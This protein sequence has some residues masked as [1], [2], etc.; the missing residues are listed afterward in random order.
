MIRKKICM[1]GAFAVGKTSL[2]ERFVKS[3]FNERYQTSLGVK[4]DKKSLL[5]DDQPLELILWDL[6]GEDEFVSLRLPYL[7]GAAGL[8]LVVDGTRPETLDTALALRDKAITEIGEVPFALLINKADLT[9]GWH[10]DPCD[11]DRLVA[12]G[13]TALETSAKTGRGVEEAFE[14]L[15]KEMLE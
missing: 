15:G 10:I 6:A 5:I 7:R 13:W 4:I 14:T 12:R 11:I 2:V 9:E 8:L 3:L 1:L